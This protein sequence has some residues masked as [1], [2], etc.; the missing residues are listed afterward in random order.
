MS[1]LLTRLGLLNL[2]TGQ[3]DASRRMLERA[4]QLAGPGFHARLA[5]LRT[6]AAVPGAAAMLGAARSLRRRL[7]RGD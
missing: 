3:K 1:R 2:L 6:F 4:T 7:K 5:A